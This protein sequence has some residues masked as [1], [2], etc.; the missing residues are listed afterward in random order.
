MPTGSQTTPCDL[1]PPE[2]EDGRSGKGL[3]VEETKRERRQEGEGE[4]EGDA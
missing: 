4:R 2:G 3:K 1:Q